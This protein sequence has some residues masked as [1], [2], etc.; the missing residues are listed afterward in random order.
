MPALL[1]NRPAPAQVSEHA[2]WSAGY[3]GRMISAAL[4]AAGAPEGLVQI[5]TG[6]GEAGSALVTGGVDKVIFV[7]STQVGARARTRTCGHT[8]AREGE[9]RRAS[10]RASAP[11]REASPFTGGGGVAHLV[12]G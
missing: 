2:S 11:V 3:Y 9:G 12:G 6:Y 4:A 7:G 8:R 1:V 10:E 5:V